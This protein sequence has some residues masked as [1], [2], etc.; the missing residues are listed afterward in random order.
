MAASGQKM[1]K[2]KIEKPTYVAFGGWGLTYLIIYW[3][4]KIFKRV[5]NKTALFNIKFAVE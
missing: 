4:K 3:N 1:A 2:T 5:K